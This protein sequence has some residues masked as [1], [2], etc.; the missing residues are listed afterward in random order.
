MA[1][2]LKIIGFC[3]HNHDNGK[4]IWHHGKDGSDSGK[5]HESDWHRYGQDKKK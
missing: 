3:C 1:A 2:M 5:D 4:A